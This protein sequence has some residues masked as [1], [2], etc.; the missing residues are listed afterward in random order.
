MAL[1]TTRG[2]PHP[3]ACSSSSPAR[4][5]ASSVRPIRS[6]AFARRDR[7]GIHAGLGAIPENRS[8]HS[9]E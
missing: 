3:R 4:A 7:H 8:S 6:R 1:P 9:S 2:E 5:M